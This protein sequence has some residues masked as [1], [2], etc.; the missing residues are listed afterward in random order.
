MVVMNQ[1]QESI[2][3]LTDLELLDISR[4]V[5][6]VVAL[7][8]FVVK[9]TFAICACPSDVGG[10]MMPWDWFPAAWG[11]TMLCVCAPDACVQSIS[12]FCVPEDWDTKILWVCP[13]TECGTMRPCD[14]PLVGMIRPTDDWGFLLL[15]FWVKSKLVIGWVVEFDAKIPTT[16]FPPG[17]LAWRIIFGT[18][19]CL[20]VT[21][22]CGKIWGMNI[23]L[24]GAMFGYFELAGR[25]RLVTVCL[26]VLTPTGLFGT[27]I[28]VIV[29]L[30]EPVSI[31]G[32][33]IFVIGDLFPVVVV[34][35]FGII[36]FTWFD[37][38]LCAELIEVTNNFFEEL[39]FIALDGG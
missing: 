2:L 37:L 17:L 14:P 10:M 7:A 31:P 34:W 1:W 38:L 36:K 5:I 4:L 32:R 21:F 29:P 25:R 6:G 24:F 33:V 26:F 20:L 8:E 15:A 28:P 18:F 39:S 13:A 11:T 27:S 19:V 35:L 23:F 12:V 9:T 16:F 3:C 22:C 30:L